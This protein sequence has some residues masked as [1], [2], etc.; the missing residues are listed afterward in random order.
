VLRKSPV[1][2]SA[3]SPSASK[4]PPFPSDIHDAALCSAKSPS[5]AKLPP[6]PGYIRGATPQ[7]LASMRFEN[8]RAVYAYGLWPER[9]P[10]LAPECLVLK[11]SEAVRDC[12]GRRIPSR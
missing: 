1:L 3:K 8:R 5:A 7:E 4:L 2:C 11:R 12:S 10:G 6:F 9:L